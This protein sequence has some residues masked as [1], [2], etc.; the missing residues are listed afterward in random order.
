MTKWHGVWKHQIM[1]LKKAWLPVYLVLLTCP[2]SPV[3]ATFQFWITNAQ[4]EKYLSMKTSKFICFQQNQH[5][6]F[7]KFILWDFLLSHRPWLLPEDQLTLCC[8]VS[9]VGTFFSIPGQN[10]TPAIKDPRHMLGAVGEFPLHR[11]LP[12]NSWPWIQGLQ[13]HPSSSL[14]SSQQCLNMKC[15]R[16]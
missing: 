16:T 10:M 3:W 2:E 15:R 12:V 7:K 14:S 8:K 1:L 5:W 13:G 6:G 11:L 9:I 4:G